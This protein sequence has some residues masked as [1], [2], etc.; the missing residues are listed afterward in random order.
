[1]IQGYSLGALVDV[2]PNFYFLPLVYSTFSLDY[3]YNLW[4]QGRAV[5]VPVIVAMIRT[6]AGFFPNSTSADKFLQFIKANFP[7]LTEGFPLHEPWFI[8]TEM[9]DGEPT[10]ICPLIAITKFL[11]FYLFPISPGISGTMSITTQI[12]P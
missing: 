4:R 2:M 5:R 6:K 1:M 11:K 10:F 9:T 8:P 3:L 7:C 12:F